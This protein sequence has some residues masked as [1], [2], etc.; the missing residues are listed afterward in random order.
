MEEGEEGEPSLVPAPLQWPKP[1]K[2]IGI[3]ACS[4]EARCASFVLYPLRSH[5]L[6]GGRD[7]RAGKQIS[8]E[9][10]VEVLE[11]M[12]YRISLLGWTW[13][14]EKE[15]SRQRSRLLGKKTE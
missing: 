14:D 6:L 11:M 2:G 1:H 13:K 4:R 12:S 5:R 15:F 8:R 3:R 7:V 10:S 9:L